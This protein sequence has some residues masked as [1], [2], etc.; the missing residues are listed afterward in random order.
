MPLPTPN[1]I[2]PG[3]EKKQLK[4]RF[5]FTEENYLPIYDVA[6]L[7]LK[8]GGY[9]RLGQNQSRTGVLPR[10]PHCYLL[11][12]APLNWS[13]LIMWVLITCIALFHS[14]TRR[15]KQA[16]RLTV[17]IGDIPRTN[18]IIVSAGRNRPAWQQRRTYQIFLRWTAK[19]FRLTH[20]ERRHCN[21]C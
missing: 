15:R 9:I 13:K 5:P 20:N 18:Q 1:K 21:C 6:G 17:S 10:T 8:R 12:V 16:D 19:E 7:L 2:K 11:C 14:L 3:L 4:Q